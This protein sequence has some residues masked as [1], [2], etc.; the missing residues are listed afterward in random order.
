MKLTPDMVNLGPFA[1]G[2]SYA[3]ADSPTGPFARLDKASG[4]SSTTADR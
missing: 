3:M 2:V 4:T 1:D